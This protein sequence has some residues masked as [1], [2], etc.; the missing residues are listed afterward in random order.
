[1]W[2]RG[3]EMKGCRELKC[4]GLFLDG[5]EERVV[6]MV[7]VRFGVRKVADRH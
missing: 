1:M 2:R 7:T 3:R 4:R 6:Y 5:W